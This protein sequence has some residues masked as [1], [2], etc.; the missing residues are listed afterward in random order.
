MVL[1]RP[2]EPA[3]FLVELATRTSASPLGPALVEHSLC[4]WQEK[5]MMR[6]PEVQLE[7]PGKNL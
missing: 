6:E 4:P 3:P 7:I 5:H 1:H 2:V